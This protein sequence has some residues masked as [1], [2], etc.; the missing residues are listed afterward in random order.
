MKDR[1]RHT[2]P[3]FE[4]A[5]ANGISLCKNFSKNVYEGGC[6]LPQVQNRRVYTHFYLSLF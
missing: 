4:A 2:I 1:T 5:A 6:K 3:W